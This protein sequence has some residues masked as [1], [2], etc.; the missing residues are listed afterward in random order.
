[1]TEEERAIVRQARTLIRT[2]GK[3]V[4]TYEDSQGCLCIMGAIMVADRG[5]AAYHTSHSQYVETWAKRLGFDTAVELFAFSDEHST[6][7]VLA[8]LETKA[9]AA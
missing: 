6:E 7:E 8:F 5:D 3:S 1:M 4:G 9:N 2:H